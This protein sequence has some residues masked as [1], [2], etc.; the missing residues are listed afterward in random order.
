MWYNFLFFTRKGMT[1]Y[2]TQ[3]LPSK[4]KKNNPLSNIILKEDILMAT[5]V[6]I[7]IKNCCII[8]FSFI[9]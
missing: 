8:F 4:I 6:E 3:I 5:F 7:N 2:V 1:T 9:M